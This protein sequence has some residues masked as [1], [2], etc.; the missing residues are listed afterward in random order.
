MYVP[1]Q[2][3]L[4]NAGEFLRSVT[5]FVAVYF[6]LYIFKLLLYALILSPVFVPLFVFSGINSVILVVAYACL[7]LAIFFVRKAWA[8]FD[9]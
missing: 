2:A 1:I 6:F 3:S 5:V 4:K 9:I 7:T 8:G